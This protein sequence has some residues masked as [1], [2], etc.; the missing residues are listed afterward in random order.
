MKKKPLA[1]RAWILWVSALHQLGIPGRCPQS[2]HPPGP[3]IDASRGSRPRAGPSCAVSRRSPTPHR[4]A[5]AAAISRRSITT[6]R[7][8]GTGARGGAAVAAAARGPPRCAILALSRRRP[9]P[10]ADPEGTPPAR[11]GSAKGAQKSWR[12]DRGLLPGGNL[13]PHSPRAGRGRGLDGA[14]AQPVGR[15]LQGLQGLL[16]GFVVVLHGAEGEAA[17]LVRQWLLG[18]GRDGGAPQGLWA[19]RLRGTACWGRGERGPGRPASLRRHSAP[20]RR[21]AASGSCAQAQY[22]LLLPPVCEKAGS[23]GSS[24]LR[25]VG[26]IWKPPLSARKDQ[27]KLFHRSILVRQSYSK[28]VFVWERISLHQVRSSTDRRN[29]S[30]TAICYFFS[31]KNSQFSNTYPKIRAFHIWEI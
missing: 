22:D 1:P 21:E 6:P 24:Q 7:R 29:C 17:R 28:A 4:A 2:K 19:A 25:A 11:S 14:D 5:P 31:R 27:L 30:R 18:L 15:V 23:S 3:G 8:S 26:R 13:Q 12:K 16:V 10:P 20:C 9:S